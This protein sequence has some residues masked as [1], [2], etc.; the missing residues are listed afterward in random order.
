MIELQEL[1]DEGD[2]GGT[3]RTWKEVAHWKGGLEQDVVNNKDGEEIFSSPTLGGMTFHGFYLLRTLLS[4]GTV[5][6]DFDAEDGRLEPVLATLTD[7]MVEEKVL[8]A[9]HRED[10]LDILCSRHRHAHAKK[11]PPPLASRMSMR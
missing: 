3:G 11:K 2:T 7:T 1:E 9:E 4:T 6:L 8:D 10:M 5:V